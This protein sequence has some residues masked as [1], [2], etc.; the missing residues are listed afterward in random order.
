M[1][2]ISRTEALNL[3]DTLRIRH[4]KSQPDFD[5]LPVS[6]T[7]KQEIAQINRLQEIRKAWRV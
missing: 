3:W 2:G 7:A 1:N 4:L 5:K 6:H